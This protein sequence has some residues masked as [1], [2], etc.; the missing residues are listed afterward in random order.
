MA[1]KPSQE[2]ALRQ[3]TCE[4]CSPKGLQVAIKAITG[5]ELLVSLCRTIKNENKR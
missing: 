4:G 3:S 2:K 1:E 5:G